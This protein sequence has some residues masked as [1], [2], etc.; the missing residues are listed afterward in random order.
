MGTL[1][2]VGQL[3]LSLSILIILHELG[4]Y[5]T[6]KWFKTRVEKFYL[7]FNPYFSLIKAK[8]IDGKWNVKTFAKADNDFP[9]DKDPDN[10]TYGIGW[11][12]LG[13]YVKISGMIDESMDKE[14]MQA[15]PQP[16]EFRTKPAWQRLIIMLAGVIVNFILGFLLMGFMLWH[17][18]EA[19]LPTSE[20]NQYGIYADSLG[21]KLGLQ[22][23]DKILKFGDKPFDKFNDRLAILELVL[24]GAKT[25]TVERNGQEKVV[26]PDPEVIK[27][28]A[29]H[30]NQK[31]PIFSF[32]LPFVAG[33]IKK[34]SPAQKAGFK[35]DDEF[36]AIDGVKTPFFRDFLA[37]VQAHPNKDV[38]VQVKRDNQI[39]DVPARIGEDGTLGI[40]PYPP[41][42]FF[43]FEHVK[44]SL[45]QA[46]PAGVKKG[47]GFIDSQIKGFGKMFSGKIKAT[48]SLGGFG[49]FAN[50]YGKQW[51]WERFWRVTAIVSLLL[52]FINLLPIPA[53][54]GGY[55]L[56]LI[57]EVITGIKP[58]DKFVETAVTIGFFLLMGLFLFSNGLDVWRALG[59]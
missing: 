56:F 46:L 29:A 34:G 48:E 39:I 35:V 43:E 19:Y 30:K 54:D 2:M 23:G 17:Y 16:W 50:M 10:T 9:E 31:E 13:G 8:K 11:L 5:S 32:R 3:I 22:T 57:F 37:Y 14:Q 33:E 6:A 51:D 49:A 4:H 27:S 7:F 26:T 55:A 53:L 52:G 41:E 47:W 58:S 28:L 20:V 40:A 36:L 44:Y 1:I 18:G 45:A 59:H 42:K 21:Q 12:P 25:I 15:E 38:I 24:N